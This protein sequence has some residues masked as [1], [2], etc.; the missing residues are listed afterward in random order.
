MGDTVNKR[1]I[2]INGVRNLEAGLPTDITFGRE[3]EVK[4]V[5]SPTKIETV[6]NGDGTVDL[7]FK[8]APVGFVSVTPKTLEEA[9]DEQP[10]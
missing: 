7:V 1:L 5:V 9:R 6:D 8:V 3:Y 10:L 4:F 2:T